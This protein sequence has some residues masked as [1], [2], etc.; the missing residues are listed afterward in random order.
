MRARRRFDDESGLVRL[1]VVRRP[2][3]VAFPL[4]PNLP[5]HLHIDCPRL[6]RARQAPKK[7]TSELP[8]APFPILTSVAEVRAWRAARQAEGHE[9]G[10]VPTMGALHDGHLSLGEPNK[11]LAGLAEEENRR[12]S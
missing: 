4:S 12:G 9:V 3:R 5:L 8:T 7:M 11:V 1:R 10:F 2:G 6:E